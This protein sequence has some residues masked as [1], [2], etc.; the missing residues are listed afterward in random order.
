MS[1]IVSNTY[2]IHATASLD[3]QFANKK[4]LVDQISGRNLIDHTRQSSATYVGSDGLIKTAATNLLLRSEEFDTNGWAKSTSTVSDNSTTSPSNA[5]NADTLTATAAS[6][7]HWLFQNVTAAS[8]TY[9]ASVYVKSDTN[10]FV[11][12][13]ITPGFATYAVITVNLTTASIS[14]TGTA[15]GAAVVSSQVID[16]GNGWRRIVLTAS[17]PSANPFVGIGMNNSGDPTYGI[18]GT[19]TWTAAGTESIYLWGAQIEAGS[20]ATSYIPTTTAAVT[21]AADVASISGT[22]FSSWYEQSEGTLYVDALPVPTSGFPSSVVSIDD[23]TVNNRIEIIKNNNQCPL[24][25]IIYEGAGQN[26]LTNGVATFAQ[27][28]QVAFGFMQDDQALYQGG[29]LVEADLSITMPTVNQMKIGLRISDS[30]YLNGTLSRLTYWPTRLSND[31]LQT[32][33]T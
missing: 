6:G 31:T 23:N 4:S 24:A 25:A 27:Q 12:L 5:A 29:S 1:F 21:R 22:N 32:I 8:G 28:S 17:I 13:S 26:S 7:E 18:Y 14:K 30:Q 16:V 19:E 33:T 11:Y 9:T 20:F 15:G 3:L 10:N 2:D